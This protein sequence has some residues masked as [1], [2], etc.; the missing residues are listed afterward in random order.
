MKKIVFSLFI[1]LVCQ[2]IIVQCSAPMSDAQPELAQVKVR[3]K[4]KSTNQLLSG[5]PNKPTVALAVGT[6]AAS[7][8]S[9]AAAATAP[10]ASWIPLIAPEAA[11]FF[12][13][14]KAKGNEKKAQKIASGALVPGPSTPT[15]PAS[16][17]GSS[18]TSPHR[19]V[20]ATPKQSPKKPTQTSP[21]K[22]GVLDLSN[23]Q[24]APADA[25][26]PRTPLSGSPQRMSAHT[27]PTKPAQTPSN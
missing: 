11:G 19:H 24:M 5:K 16:K 22:D 13:D 14:F 17:H 9:S 4:V 25:E 23:V 26:S 6:F 3:K 1:F 27:S 21:T 8:T 10:T 12:D 15:K 20:A 18:H 2:S 7:S